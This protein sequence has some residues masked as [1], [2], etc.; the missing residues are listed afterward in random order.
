MQ[1]APD[2]T[3]ADGPDPYGEPDPEWLRID[4]REHLASVEVMGTRVNYA[5]LGSGPPI[6][7]VHG[8]AGCWQNWL[9][10]M[11]HFA[12]AGYRTIALD[13][14]GFA[15]SP[16]PPWEISIASY[17]DLLDAFRGALD[18]EDCIVVGNSMGGFI[19]ADL[20]TRQ[21]Q[22]LRGLVLV[23]PAGISYPRIN[24][25]VAETLALGAA[26]SAKVAYRFR[27]ASL[28]R[29]RLRR[30]AFGEVFHSPELLR[31]ELLWEFIAHAIT[32]P[33]FLAAVRGMVGYDFHAR[34]DRIEVPT[35]IVWGRNDHVVFSR[36]GP[37]FLRR[38]PGST[39]EVYA[40]T[41]HVAMAERPV[42]FNRELER[43]VST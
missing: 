23:S 5:E 21:P 22:W 1:F 39:L 40:R 4:W 30:M 17:A 25:R 11:P 31:P 41:G 8:L 37:E 26:I 19:A 14:P 9:E 13:L 7:F 35:S 16:L 12:S 43:F 3:P 33:G 20:A 28:T 27:H 24:T 18:A 38:I 10:N 6:V 2:A 34:L 29:G 15:G 32:A 42:R 36:D